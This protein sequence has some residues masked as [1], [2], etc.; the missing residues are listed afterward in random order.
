MTTPLD[1]IS[2][3]LDLT[4][5]EMYAAILGESPSKGAK[6]PTLWNAAFKGEG[7]SGVM[8]PMDVTEE[9]LEP[10]VGAL[11]ED[12]A[13]IGGAVTMPYK[14]QIL[15]LLDELESEAET[16]GAVNCIYRKG[17]KLVGANTDGAG[18]LW[19][20]E[21]ALE[22]PLDGATALTIGTGG[23]G[24]AVATYIAN[25]IGKNGTLIIANRSVDSRDAFAKK[26]SGTCNIKTV[27]LPLSNDIA[28]RLD[29]IV[30][31]SSVGF[32]TLKQDSKGVYSLGV[33]SP[34]GTVAFQQVQAG[35]D[36][37]KV[38]AATN[39]KEIGVNMAETTAFLAKTNDA[40]VFDIVYQPKRTML[41]QLAKRLKMETLT[42]LPMN[43]EQAVIA[44]DKAVTGAGVE[45][46]GVDRVR[47]LMQAVA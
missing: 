41:L 29:V 11:R 25:A 30:N 40:L 37:L 17:D 13:F 18:A 7:L 14:I 19:S 44:F 6:S 33:F 38:F 15:S 35:D 45:T 39:A 20:L 12:K 31:C 5:T 26:L 23:A 8:H 34:L 28:D 2:N 47:E 3:K 24:L 27:G 36:A 4:A 9:N 46:P 22:K 21:N 16:I 32:E 42:G 1:F 10:L 43:L